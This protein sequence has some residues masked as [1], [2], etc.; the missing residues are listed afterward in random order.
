MSNRPEHF[1]HD[2]CPECGTPSV[3]AEGVPDQT[4]RACPKC[5]HTWAEDLSSPPKKATKEDDK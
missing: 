1:D 2:D 4:F 5:H 3:P